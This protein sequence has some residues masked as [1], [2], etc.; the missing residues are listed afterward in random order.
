MQPA[1]CQLELSGL[2]VFSLGSIWLRHRQG[3]ANGGTQDSFQRGWDCIA[4]LNPTP[5]AH[6]RKWGQSIMYCYFY[7]WLGSPCLQGAQNLLP[8]TLRL[9]CHMGLPHSCTLWE[10]KTRDQGFIFLMP[11]ISQ[12]F[13]VC[14][15]PCY[16][17]IIL[18]WGLIYILS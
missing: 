3:T 17:Y 6:Q 14:R 2:N 11:K 13:A 10:A 8:S 4:L 9:C 1:I 7:L 15:N 18:Q 5:A 12:C 16:Q